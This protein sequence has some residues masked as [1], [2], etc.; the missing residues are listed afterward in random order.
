MVMW[1]IKIDP[2]RAFQC[3]GVRSHPCCHR[4]SILCENSDPNRGCFQPQDRGAPWGGVESIAWTTKP[5]RPDWVCPIFEYLVDHQQ[6]ITM[7]ISHLLA[8]A[9]YT[10]IQTCTNDLGCPRRAHEP[11]LCQELVRRKVL[12]SVTIAKH[13]WTGWWYTYPSEKYDFVSWDN[14][15][16][17]MESHKSHVPVTTNITKQWKIRWQALYEKVGIPA[18]CCFKLTAPGVGHP[19]FPRY[20]DP[21]RTISAHQP[22]SVTGCHRA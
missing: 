8:G 22:G 6:G 21:K 7:V 5:D 3:N 4:V 11:N 17:C 13:R 15:S 10:Q 1:W 18:S 14:C 16:Q 2:S 19:F 20:L 12:T 9:L